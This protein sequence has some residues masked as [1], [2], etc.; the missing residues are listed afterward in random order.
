MK[1]SSTFQTVSVKSTHLL[2]L[3]LLDGR[4]HQGHMRQVRRIKSTTK[5]TQ[6]LHASLDVGHRS[7]QVQT[8]SLGTRKWLSKRASGDPGGSWR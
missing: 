5:N 3:Q 2:E 6:A 8:Q 4:L 7:R 1:L